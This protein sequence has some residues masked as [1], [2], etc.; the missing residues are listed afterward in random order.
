[1]NIIESFKKSTRIRKKNWT[2]EYWKIAPNTGEIRDHW[3]TR[4]NLMIYDLTS[5]DWE[6]LL[7]FKEALDLLILGKTIKR[8][9][10]KHGL[11]R[12]AAF[13]V[14]HGLRRRV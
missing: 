3:D 9:A 11:R 13:A 5:D 1:M 6:P 12:K 2:G 7:T 14:K 10:V 8:V 4:V